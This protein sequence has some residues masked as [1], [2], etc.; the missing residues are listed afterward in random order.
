VRGRGLPMW[1]TRPKFLFT[2]VVVLLAFGVLRNVPVYP[3]TILFP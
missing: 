2:M 3:L 1:P